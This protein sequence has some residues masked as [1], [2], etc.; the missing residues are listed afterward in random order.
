MRTT[1]EVEQWL[2]D[3]IETADVASDVASVRT[4]A[5]AGLLT[6]DR[7]L[8]LRFANGL[9]VQLT[10]V[11]SANPVDVDESEPAIGLLPQPAEAEG[12]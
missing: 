11:R 10:I 2:L 6:R 5:D 9:E 7:G 3:A 12:A 4:F 1:A 8:V